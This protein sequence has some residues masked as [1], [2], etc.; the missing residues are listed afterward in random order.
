VK[1]SFFIKKLHKIAKPIRLIWL[2]GWGVDHKTLLPLSLFFADET[3]N[4]LL[5]LPGFG[6]SPSPK[7]TWN[8]TD[9]TDTIAKWLQTLKPQK[10]TYIIG[11]SFGGQIAI[12]IAAAYPKLVKGL[13]LLGLLVYKENIHCFLKLGI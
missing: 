7:Q 2:H 6:Q 12:K 4:Y 11:H 9:Y 5:D 3:E 1:P 8:T 10:P 13:V